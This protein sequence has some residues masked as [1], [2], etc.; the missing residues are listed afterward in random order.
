MLYIFSSNY[1]IDVVKKRKRNVPEKNLLV[2]HYTKEYGK[3]IMLQIIRRF[4]IIQTL[5]PLS[6]GEG[7]FASN[8]VLHNVIT[9]RMLMDDVGD[10]YL[11]NRSIFGGVHKG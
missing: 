4:I 9:D 8:S 1:L 3:Y 7:S 6:W 5:D 11:E 2:L 10:K